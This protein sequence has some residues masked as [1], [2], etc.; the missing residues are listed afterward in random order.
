MKGFLAN[1]FDL[2]SPHVA[3]FLGCGVKFLIPVIGVESLLS[4][5]NS[6]TWPLSTGNL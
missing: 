1:T 3:A 5:L 2:D 6:Q 4:I